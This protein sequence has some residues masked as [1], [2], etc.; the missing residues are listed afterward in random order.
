MGRSPCELGVT[1]ASVG[2]SGSFIAGV[3]TAGTVAGGVVT[4]SVVA[5]CVV[6]G[7]V[8][9]GFVT[10][11]TAGTVATIGVLDPVDPR[12]SAF[13]PSGSSP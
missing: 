6:T 7:V 10:G 13:V 4:A 2:C 11:V 5:A 8:V 12:P 3:V 1:G 9:E